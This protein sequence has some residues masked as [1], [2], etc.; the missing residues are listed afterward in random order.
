M[1]KLSQIIALANGKKARSQAEITVLHHQLQKAVL[2]DGITRTYRPLN[3]DGEK[4]PPESKKVQLRV[5]EMIS[6]ARAAMSDVIDIVVTQDTANTKAF[7]N[8]IVDGKAIATDVP[9]CNLLFLE[10]HLIDL[11]TFVDK[12]PVLDPAES[13]ERNEEMDCYATAPFETI[14]TKK[15][16]RN[17]VKYDAT[18]EHP[19]QVEMYME[20]VLVGN[21]TTTKFSGAILDA[22]RRAMLSRIRKLQ[23]AVKMAREEANSLEV[24]DVAIAKG[25][26]D[27]VFDA[28]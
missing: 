15:L 20:D 3:E 11:A 26:F 28:P 16:P 27:F 22:D 1:P 7:A 25:I 21:W 19:A 13:W 10:K 8:I 6:R 24:K 4:F 2:L 9:V 5:T 23:D 17:H 14:K 12:L 18:K